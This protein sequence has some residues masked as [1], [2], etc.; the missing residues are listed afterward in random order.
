MNMYEQRRRTPHPDST[1]PIA[2][3]NWIHVRAS[4]IVIDHSVEH[5]QD[6]I[7]FQLGWKPI[8]LQMC[9]PRKSDMRN[10]RWCS[11]QDFSDL[12]PILS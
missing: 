6:D 12:N 7:R 4:D 10:M 8:P 1:L 3:F 2:I 5:M 11:L 9:L